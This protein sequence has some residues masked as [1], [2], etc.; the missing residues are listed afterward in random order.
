MFT[1]TI[2]APWRRARWASRRIGPGAAQLTLHGCGTA[3][4]FVTAV[5]D[6]NAI[7]TP[8]TRNIA[9]RRRARADRDVP[10]AFTPARRSERSVESIPYWPASSE[11]FEAVLHASQPTFRIERARAGGVWNTG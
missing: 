11:W 4:P 3:C 6:R 1:I 7:R 2:R 5:Y 9:I 8:F 10:V